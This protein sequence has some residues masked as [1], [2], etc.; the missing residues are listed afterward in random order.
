VLLDLSRTT[1]D[2][3]L[4]ACDVAR[5]IGREEDGDSSPD[6]GGD[7]YLLELL[8]RIPFAAD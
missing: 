8:R 6:F 7:A 4:D 2:E 3:E 5:I 1:G